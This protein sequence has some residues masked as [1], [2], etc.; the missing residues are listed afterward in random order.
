[1][2]TDR[3]EAIKWVCSLHP[4]AIY[5][6]C[7]GLARDV[8]ETADQL[9]NLYL[10][11]GM[12]QALAVGVGIAQNT[13]RKV[14]VLDGDGNAVMGA[15]MWTMLHTVPNLTYYVLVNGTYET[16]GGQHVILPSFEPEDLY[17]ISIER[18]K[19]GRP[20]GEG[21]RPIETDEGFLCPLRSKA[22]F[23]QWL[24]I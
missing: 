14:V 6:I 2:K 20:K 5:I 16:T 21:I 13:N 18:G 24:R 22:R 4:G 17:T 19:I 23:L 15:S 8:F 9:N 1:M 11:H 3:A 10:V 7:N 12:G